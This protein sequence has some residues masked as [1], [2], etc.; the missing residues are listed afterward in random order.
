MNT[1]QLKDVIKKDLTKINVDIEAE[2]TISFSATL[3]NRS[4]GDYIFADKQGFHFVSIG[5]RGKIEAETTYHNLDDILFAV[6]W[7]ITSRLSVVFAKE[8]RKQGEDWRR[9]MFP[10]RLELLKMLGDI[11]YLKGQVKINQILEENPYND[12]L[13]RRGGNEGG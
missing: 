7:L 3:G 9:K 11:Y 13:F 10:K 1:S 4:P 6:Y 12:E 2:T 5:D 8:N